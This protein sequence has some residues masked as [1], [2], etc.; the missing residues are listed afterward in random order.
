VQFIGKEI[1]F[2]DL[3]YDADKPYSYYITMLQE[4]AGTRRWN[5]GPITLPH[6]GVKRS[7][8][9]MKSFKDELEMAGFEVRITPR[10]KDK[11]SSGMMSDINQARS[12]FPRC[13]FD[14]ERC[15]VGIEMLTDYH[16]EWDAERQ[17][18]KDKPY[19]DISSNYSDSFI[20]VA[21]NLPSIGQKPEHQTDLTE[22]M[23]RYLSGPAYRALDYN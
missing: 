18:Y 19:H 5:Y 17:L 12:M 20:Q 23:K 1:R 2:V 11:S 16:K 21:V 15:K 10:T 4:K 6:D 13:W 22:A 7:A 9:N 3:F 14:A 8:S